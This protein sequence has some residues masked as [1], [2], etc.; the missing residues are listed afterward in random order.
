MRAINNVLI[1]L[2]CMFNEHLKL[3]NITTLIIFSFFALKRFIP[4]LSA[5]DYFNSGLAP[6][7][8]VCQPIFN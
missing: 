6:N 5:Y 4:Y 7:M 1:E 3:I 2:Y 8:D